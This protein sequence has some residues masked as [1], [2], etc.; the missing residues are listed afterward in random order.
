MTYCP[1]E[2]EPVLTTCLG[3]G[4]EAVKWKC[5]LAPCSHMWPCVTVKCQTYGSRPEA[6]SAH[7][8][9]TC[10]ATAP[11]LI[12]HS[13]SSLKCVIGSVLGAYIRVYV[14]MYVRT[15]CTIMVWAAVRMGIFISAWAVSGQAKDSGKAGCRPPQLYVWVYMWTSAETQNRDKG[16]KTCCYSIVCRRTNSDTMAFA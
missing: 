6:L 13:T 12:G 10:P 16:L 1:N 9:P 8:S 2:Y 3:N 4:A 14:C 15:E 7:Q 11:P 5:L